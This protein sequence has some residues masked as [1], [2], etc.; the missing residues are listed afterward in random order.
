MKKPVILFG[1]VAAALVGVFSFIR[2]AKPGGPTMVLLPFANEPTISFRLWFRAGSQNDPAGKQGLAA[3]TALMM[4]EGSTKKHS[5]EE[6]LELLYPMASGIS[7]QIDKEMTVIYGRTHKDNLASYYDLLNEVVMEPAFNEEDF[8]RVKTDMLNYLENQLRYSNDE[9]LGKEVLSEFVY[10]GTPYEHT[11]AGHVSALKS[12][13]LEDIK[14]FYRTYYTRENLVVG[15]A[16]GYESVFPE[17]V[18][19]DFERLP[20]GMPAGPAKSAAAAVSGLD[21]T[22]VEKDAQAT[23]ISFGFP[24]DVLRGDKD[25]YALAIANSWLGEHRNSS[26]HLYQVIR[27]VRGLNYGDYSYIEAFPNGG[28][29]TF[30]PPNVARRQQMFQIWIRPV[31]NEAR[32]FAFRA[33]LRELQKLVDNGMTEA[34]FELTRKFLKSYILHYAP[35]P[36]MKLGYALDDVF[37]G[38][39]GHHLGNFRTM[40]DQLTLEDVNNAVK[41]HLQ[42]KNLKIVFITNEAE[43][44]RAMLVNNTPSPIEYATPKS[45]EILD[46][47][48]VISAYPISVK[49]ENIRIVPVDK[50]FE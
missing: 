22:I 26:S 35:T 18:E 11:D 25:F 24:I 43:K 27:E 23:A 31:R 32:L 9:E 48:R 21:V 20:A 45:Q 16:G 34:E 4:T 46:E 5:Y 3:L 2:C 50:V 13:T 17:R 28:M 7:G 42:Y 15:L 29:L 49:A 37:Y 39:K 38:I 41:K 44:L 33:A 40:L 14:K 8:K 19:K 6:I 47:D 1:L 10:R 36:M 12:I 30:P